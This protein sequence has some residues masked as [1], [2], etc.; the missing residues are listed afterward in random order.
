MPDKISDLRKQTI[1]Q[2][3]AAIAPTKRDAL[4]LLNG[5]DKVADEPIR[6]YRKDGQIESQSETTRDVETGAVV[7]GRALTWTYYPTGEVDEITIVETDA[8]QKEIGWKLIK[9]FPD[10]TQPKTF[11]DRNDYQKFLDGK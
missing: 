7:S 4:I 8:A 11:V 6:T 5:G 10:G 1:T 9:H 2:L 3:R